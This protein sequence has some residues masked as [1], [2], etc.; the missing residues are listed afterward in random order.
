M[1]ELELT[2]ITNDAVS[3]LAAGKIS[4]RRIIVGTVMVR[5]CP[6]EP[7]ATQH[8]SSLQYL[9]QTSL[10]LPG[11]SLTLL[12]LPRAGEKYTATRI[13]ELFDAPAS[14]PGWPFVTSAEPGVPE[15]PGSSKVEEAPVIKSGAAPVA[16]TVATL[17]T[18]RA[19]C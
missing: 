19:R 14:S 1:S 7:L 3:T 16:R 10:N 8:T 11:F 5:S 6:L 9:F 13:L 12:L 18:C 4:V 15:A 17:R 2:S